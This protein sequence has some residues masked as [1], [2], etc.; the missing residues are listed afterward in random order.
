[1][2]ERSPVAVQ[3]ISIVMDIQ[4]FY[5]NFVLVVQKQSLDIRLLPKRLNVHRCSCFTEENLSKHGMSK[6]SL[7][8]GSKV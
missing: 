1:M 5:L 7:V 2:Y 3:L 8:F 6:V 4:S